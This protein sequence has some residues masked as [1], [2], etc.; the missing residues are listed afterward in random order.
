MFVNTT[1]TEDSSSLECEAVSHTLPSCVDTLLGP[2]DPEDEATVTLHN[3]GNTH[4][5]KQKH[6]CPNLR[7]QK[8]CPLYCLQQRQP[9]WNFKIIHLTC[10]L[11]E[12]DTPVTCNFEPGYNASQVYSTYSCAT[13]VQLLLLQVFPACHSQNKTKKKPNQTKPNHL[14]S[15]LQS[16]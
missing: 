3:N 7:S 1:L 6:C 10:V 4:T 14:P 15:Y 5:T 13:L 11:F 8:T 2:V 16:L 9:A 12:S